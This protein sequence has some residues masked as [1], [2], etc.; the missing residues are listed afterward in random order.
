MTATE[1]MSRAEPPRTRRQQLRSVPDRADVLALCAVL[2]GYP[3]AAFDATRDDLATAV[4]TLRP[5]KPATQLRRFWRQFSALSRFEAKSLY[6]ET[7]DLRRRSSLFLTYYLH[8]DTRRRGL[9]LLAL[10]QRYRAAGFDPGD[11]ELPDYLPMALEFAALAGPDTG[12]AVLRVHRT[13]IEAIR[14][15][16]ADRKSCYVDILAAICALLGPVGPAQR[17]KVERLM[18]AGP[19][20]EQLGLTSSQD[21]NT[22]VWSVNMEVPFGP[23]E[24]TFTQEGR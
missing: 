16:L 24:H 17:A 15:G 20:T 8:G 11:V 19:P 7:F 3:D 10:K 21:P 5:S 6:V 13:G 1:P 4:A 23:P 22:P 12:E 9:A 2:L 18:Q 14:E